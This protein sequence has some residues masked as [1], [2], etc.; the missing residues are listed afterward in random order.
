MPPTV[1]RTVFNKGNTLRQ[2]LMRVRN[3]RQ[4]K[5]SR[6][7]ST[8]VYIGETRRNRTERLKEHNTQL[9]EII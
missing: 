5:K 6:I 3:K 7:R 1:F 8:L 4:E 2:K 9:G